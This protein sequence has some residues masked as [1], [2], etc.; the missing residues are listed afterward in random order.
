MKKIFFLLALSCVLYNA[1][2]AN[3]VAKS[4]TEQKTRS[5]AV[6][7]ERPKLKYD[8]HKHRHK[9]FRHTRHKK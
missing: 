1:G 8:K 4:I 3:T 6:K 7:S 5:A 9:H 2:M